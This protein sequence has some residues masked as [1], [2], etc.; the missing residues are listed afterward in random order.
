MDNTTTNIKV[1]QKKTLWY[2]YIIAFFLII[3]AYWGV[4]TNSDW[5]GYEYWFDYDATGTDRAFVFLSAWFNAQGLSF[6]MLYRFHILLIAFFYTLLFKRL[7]ANP[8][9]FSIV[10]LLFSYDAVGNQIRFFVGLPMALLALYDIV[11]K[12]Y[13]RA[14]LLGVMA[15]FFHSSLALLFA[16]FFFYYFIL[17]HIEYTWRVFFIIVANFVL[18]YVV[19]ETNMS[20]SLS[21]N[22]ETYLTSADRVSSVIG[23]IYNLITALLYIGFAYVV[24]KEI[25]KVQPSFTTTKEYR[26]LYTCIMMGTVLFICSIQTQ[27]IAHRMM[28]MAMM[29]IW[30]TYF[31]R[32]KSL[33]VKIINERVNTAVVIIFIFVTLHTLGFFTGSDSYIYHVREMLN[34]Y[35]LK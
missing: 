7:K 26:Y 21:G 8:I 10:L 35:T 4:T 31:I 12:K 11:E 15:F 1:Q 9:I 2:Q 24:N 32:A 25:R 16:I 14:T 6:R 19:H 22:Y 20:A 27:I 3:I 33:R 29:P 34:S 18:Y 13:I 5:G 30:L 28:N 17:R 23:G